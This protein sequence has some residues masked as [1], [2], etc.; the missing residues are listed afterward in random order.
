MGLTNFRSLR[1]SRF[2]RV[3]G[4]LFSILMV[5]S[6]LRQFWPTSNGRLAAGATLPEANLTYIAGGDGTLSLADLR[7]K[8]V[9]VNFWATWCGY[10]VKELPMLSKMQAKYGADKVAVIA[11][12]DDGID[13]TRAFLAQRPAL[14][15]PFLHDPGGSLGRQLHIRNIPFTVFLDREGK[16]ASD[17]TG[18]LSEEETVKR[19]DELLAR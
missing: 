2:G 17:K 11:V 19:L 15:L 8:P 10:C 9:L 1:W 6:L 18:I 12:N 3:I 5:G 13:A 7:G 4:G 16:V 14:S